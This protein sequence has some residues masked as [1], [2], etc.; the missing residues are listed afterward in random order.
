MAATK[1]AARLKKAAA[2]K[3]SPRKT[4]KTYQLQEARVVVESKGTGKPL[5]LLHS[6]DRYEHNTA[7][8]DELAKTHRVIMPWMP[9]FDK[10]TLP[11]S[12]TSID[13]ISYLYL[14]LLDQMKLTDVTVIGFSVG[15]W[16]ANEIA[17]K[18]CTRLKKIV[19]VAP[20]GIKNGGPYDRD[21]EDI[22]F[23]RFDVVKKM[24][25]HNIK[26]DPRVLT[27]MSEAEA[28]DEA[29]ARET[30]AQLCWDPYFHNP[31]LRYRLNRVAV[32]TLLIWGAND[33]IVKPSYGR[34]YAKKIPGAKFASIPKA[35]HFPHVEQP[36]AFMKILRPFLR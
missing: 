21:I 36:D 22:Y 9:G 33:G 12:V 35:G 4:R 28:M 20:V 26:K 3:T 18:N 27:D 23:H 30:T 7:L 15:G 5:L 1:K 32:K 11:D 16:I 19:L 24:K 6:E 8:I 2:P 29:R 10:S 13:D 17:T 25:F 14:D 31:S 34:A